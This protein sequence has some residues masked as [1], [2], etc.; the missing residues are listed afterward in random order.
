MAECPTLKA[1]Y[2]QGKTFE[3]AVENIKD[4]IALCLADLKIKG[5]GIPP[6]F[7]IIGAKRVEVTA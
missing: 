7:E 1:C 4:V 5:T 2:A 6:Q 3:A